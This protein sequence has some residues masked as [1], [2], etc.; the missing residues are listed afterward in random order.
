MLSDR[1]L[2]LTENNFPFLEN[3]SLGSLETVFYQ[4]KKKFIIFVNTD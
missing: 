3:Q 1:K 4:M 2:R